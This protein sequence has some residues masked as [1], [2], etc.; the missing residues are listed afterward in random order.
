[1]KLETTLPE[2]PGFLH[3]VPLLN[4][5]ALLLVFQV[6]GPAFM[7]QGGVAV[8]MPSS[9]FQ[10]ERF[11]DPLVITVTA[12]DPPAVFL[13]HEQIAM[14][15]LGTRLDEARHSGEVEGRMAVLRFDA[16]IPAAVERQVAELALAR[17]YRVVLAGT[18][19]AVEPERRAP[20]EESRPGGPPPGKEAGT[21]GGTR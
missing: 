8:E 18:P 3:A 6:L 20:A 17:G 13:G 4:L 5:F 2:H 9:R 15:Q 16:M 14:E 1:M 11:E 21:E 19:A 10:M 7:Q 12:G